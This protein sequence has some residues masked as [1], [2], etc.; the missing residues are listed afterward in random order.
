[1]EN[2]CDG[3]WTEIR[4]KR[5]GANRTESQGREKTAG[6][7]LMGQKGIWRRV[8]LEDNSLL[9]FYFLILWRHDNQKLSSQ[10]Q[11]TYS[12]TKLVKI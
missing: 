11:S 8:S 7:G 2:H 3:E 4:Y 12:G 1:M 6:E 9:Y 10:N 5:T